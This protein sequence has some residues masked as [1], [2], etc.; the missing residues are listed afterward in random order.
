MG[1]SVLLWSPD[2]RRVA[3]EV[4]AQTWQGDKQTQVRD[5]WVVDRDGKNL[6]RALEGST[7]GADGRPT[8]KP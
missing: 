5:V 6:R 1:Q 3:F 8:E 4:W 7:I 2:G